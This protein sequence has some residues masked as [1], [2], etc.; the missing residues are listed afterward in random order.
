MRGASLLAA[1]ALSS[2]A[3]AQERMPTDTELHALACVPLMNWSVAYLH[4]THAAID[5][6]LA[7]V[8]GLPEEQQSSAY[9]NYLKE[10]SSKALQVA[11]DDHSALDRLKAYILPRYASIDPVAGTAAMN[12]GKADAE[13]I[14]AYY[15]RCAACAQGAFEKNPGHPEAADACRQNECKR[16]SVQDRLESC[17]NPTW[18]PF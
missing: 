4:D 5:S 6:E 7:R 11:Q 16:P 12:R 14:Q 9:V 1:L 10:Q 2:P 8:R 13:E 17:R 18:L 3:L 15:H